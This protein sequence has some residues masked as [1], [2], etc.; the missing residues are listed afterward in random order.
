M[1][2]ELQT[3]DI[4]IRDKKGAENVV[5]D[6]LSR[7]E[8]SHDDGIPIFDGMIDDVLYAIEEKELP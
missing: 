4:E 8:D 7:F 6:H 1:V 2:L 3:F 5:A